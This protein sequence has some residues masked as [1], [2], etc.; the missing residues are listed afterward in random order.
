MKEAEFQTTQLGG[1]MAVA[2]ASATAP[3]GRPSFGM[4]DGEEYDEDIEEP[5]EEISEDES[6]EEEYEDDFEEDVYTEDDL[7]VAEEI[8]GEYEHRAQVGHHLSTVREEQE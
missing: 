5:L 8:M 3:T 2:A 7:D 1:G 4:A 6:D